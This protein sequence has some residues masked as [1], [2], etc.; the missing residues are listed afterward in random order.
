M[1]IQHP[2]APYQVQLGQWLISPPLYKSTHS[3]KIEYLHDSLLVSPTFKI[4][5]VIEN[6]YTVPH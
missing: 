5:L 1:L 4:L 3:L 2:P 6:K